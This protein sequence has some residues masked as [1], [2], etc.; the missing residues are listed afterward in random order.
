[1]RRVQVNVLSLGVGLLLAFWASRLIGIDSFPPFLDEGIHVN[2][3]E[4]ILKTGPLS[5]SDDGR[6][7]VLWWYLLFQS[8][9]SAP[10]WTARVATLLAVL[11]GVAAVIGIGRLAAGVW[12]A[13][14]AGLFY[15][16]S[17]YHLFFERMA[18]A[19]PI[20]ASAISVALYFAYRLSR[21]VNRWDACAC[22]LA[23]FAA[24][25]AKV[26]AI[27]YIV[28]PIAASLSLSPAC[29]SRR[30]KGKWLAVALAIAVGFS[31]VF[32]LIT[33]SRGYNPFVY[34][35]DTVN[36]RPDYTLLHMMLSFIPRS[37]PEVL[38]ML[39]VY[40]DPLVAVLLLLAVIYLMIRRQ[41]YL[42]LCLFLP[43]M[44]LLAS[45]RQGSRHLIEPMTILLLCG[46]IA[47]ACVVQRRGRK[48]QA[49]SLGLVLVWGIA[50]WLPFAWTMARNPFALPYPE[51]DYIEYVVSDAT[52]FGLRELQ[53]YLIRENARAV[54]GVFSNCQGFRYMSW[55]ALAV[56][57]PVLNPSGAHIQALVNELNAR[58][59]DG[60][61]A[62][63]EEDNNYV[64]ASAPGRLVA[65]IERPGGRAN[66]RVYDLTP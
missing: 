55:D 48:I 20:S 40:L 16:F 46:G 19:D 57:C 45:K 62:V 26:S 33:V 28:V 29:H 35:F 2:Y 21:R 9:A 52:G 53:E 25:G 41:L 37:Q 22:G 66:L 64:P 15:L 38:D 5:G 18:L 60:T 44:V 4:N 13:V 11:P 7:F 1:L 32:T 31:A 49:L 56:T 12:G 54:I 34:L 58:K 51:R 50:H 27:P 39:L 23:L 14:F 24:F 8:P 6:Q 61:F 30:E 42:P 10:I 43:L 47:L 63:L 65:V 17:T 36:T 59:A 3:S